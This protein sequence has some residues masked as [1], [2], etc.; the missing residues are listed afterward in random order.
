MIT[1]Q[2]VIVASRRASFHQMITP[3]QTPWFALGVSLISPNHP[4]VG[5]YEV[6]GRESDPCGMLFYGGG[7]DLHMTC[8]SLF[9]TL[10]AYSTYMRLRTPY[11][12]TVPSYDVQGAYIPYLHPTSYIN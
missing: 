10:P 8:L 2:S 7:R 12:D 4:Y 5:G 1:S 3:A 9:I 11:E 6:R